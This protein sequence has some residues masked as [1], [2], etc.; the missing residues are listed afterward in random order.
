MIPIF[1]QWS[2]YHLNYRSGISKPQREK[3]EMEL[4]KPISDKF[5][6]NVLYVVISQANYGIDFLRL[7]YPNV[8][9]FSA[10]GEGDIPIPL[11]K[12]DL[13]FIPI[14]STIFPKYDVGFY[15]SIDHGHRKK[16]L[17]HFKLLLDDS[18]YTYKLGP[19]KT[20]IEDMYVYF[21][22][23]F[24]FCIFILYFS[25]IFLMGIFIFSH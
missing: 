22:S 25:S 21:Y 20:W 15:G 18:K 5:R 3:T 11:I 16:L 9:I 23:A 14:N 10:G 19:S 6:K 13:G 8:L 4:Y 2:D 12:G 17:D 24:L 7:N 1:V